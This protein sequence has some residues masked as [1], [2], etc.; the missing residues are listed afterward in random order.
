MIEM[1]YQRTKPPYLSNM[2]ARRKYFEH[3]RKNVC[4]TM[5]RVKQMAEQLA[6]PA[7]A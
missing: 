6:A 4:D 1:K 5:E 7:Q 2:I 3:T